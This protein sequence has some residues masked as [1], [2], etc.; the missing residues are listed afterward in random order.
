MYQI[1]CLFYIL[2]FTVSADTG[3]KIE[4]ATSDSYAGPVTNGD[5]KRVLSCTFN[6]EIKEED[7]FELP[8]LR[9]IK[10]IQQKKIDAFYPVHVKNKNRKTVLYP[11][12]MDEVL[13]ISKKELD[14]SKQIPVGL[15]RGGHSNILKTNLNFEPYFVVSKVSSLIKGLESSRVPA[16]IIFRS[17]IP[18]SFNVSNYHL[19]TIVY[20]DFG[21]E[22]NP[23]IED[24]SNLSLDTLQERFRNC[25][26]KNY[27]VLP[28]KTKERI[29]ESFL[30]DYSYLRS[31]FQFERKEVKEIPKKEKLWNLNDKE[32]I[33]SILNNEFTKK[34]RS[35]KSRFNYIN[36]AFIF[37]YQGGLVSSLEMTSDFDQSDE[38]KF[39]ILLDKTAFSKKNISNIYFDKSAS[40]F[41]VGIFIRLVDKKGRFA[42]GLCLGVDVN[43]LISFYDIY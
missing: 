35:I 18:K 30:N 6:S 34:L 4:I 28:D 3:N 7:F 25:V 32:L 10:Y 13:L 2:A 5:I 17:Q 36:E 43:K 12:Y 19:R 38:I 41:Q 21:I 29:V 14:F 11:I 24:K 37:N 27:F 26:A 22:L 1:L 20:E 16:I 15:I 31:L 33:N 42:G 23:L 39:K 8:Y 40:S 9:G